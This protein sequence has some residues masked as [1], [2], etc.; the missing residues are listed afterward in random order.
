V[1]VTKQ[2]KPTEG[3]YRTATEVNVLSPEIINVGNGRQSSFAGRQK[4]G[5][6]YGEMFLTPRGLRQWYGIEWKLQ[7]LGRSGVV[8]EKDIRKQP[9]EGR[10]WR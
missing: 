3:K 10:M 8:F 2:V 4:K 1:E 5:Y 9:E 7:E 6:R